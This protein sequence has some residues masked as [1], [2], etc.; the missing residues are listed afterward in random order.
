MKKC[1]KCGEI[2][3]KSEFYKIPVKTKYNC[4]VRPHCKICESKIQKKRREERNKSKRVFFI[5]SGEI[6]TEKKCTTCKKIKEFN[7][8]THDVNR[9]YYRYTDCKSCIN[10]RRRKQYK[11]STKRRKYCSDYSKKNRNRILN[12]DHYAVSKIIKYEESLTK[13]DIPPEMIEIKKK[14]LKLKREI[15]NNKLITIKTKTNE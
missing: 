4:G 2:K 12:S 9:K 7:E 1:G 5:E 3:D 13:K 6:I 15:K 8:F 11:E 14:Y 10:K